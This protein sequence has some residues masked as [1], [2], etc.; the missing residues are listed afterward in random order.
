[1]FYLFKS[2]F[3]YAGRDRWKIILF[4]FLHSLSFCGLLAKPFAF[5]KAINE[6]QIHGIENLNPAISWLGLY[7][8][9]FFVF[10]VFHR[11][12]QIFVVTTALNTQRRF[13]STMYAEL[14]RLPL[15]WHVGHHSG[16]VVNRINTAG[17]ALR[18]FTY[19]M[20]PYLE[21]LF[22]SVGPIVLLTTISWQAAVISFV[23][24]A[25]N[26]V[27]V[28]ILNRKIQ[29]VMHRQNESNH[30]FTA[31]LIDFVSNIRTIITFRIGRETGRELNSKFDEFYRE[32]MKEF[33]LNQPRC[34][35]I[36]FGIIVTEITV[37]SYYL[38]SLRVEMLPLLVGDL[39]I[40]VSY[41]R[42]IS[43]TFFRMTSS[44]YETMGWK[45]AVKSVEPILDGGADISSWEGNAEQWRE[46]K[47][48]GLCFQY[49]RDRETLA[50]ID[51]NLRKGNKIALVGASGSGKSTLLQ[52][53]AG[54]YTPGAVKVEVD[55]RRL[56]NLRGL[57]ESALLIPQDSEI[58]QG[59]ILYNITFGLE[60]GSDELEQVVRAAQFQEVVHRLPRG[61]NTDIREKGVNLSGGERQRLALARGL[62]FARSKALLLLDEVT[63]NVDARNEHHIFRQV[64]ARFSDRCIIAAVHRLHLLENFDYVYMM[65]A[66]RVVQRGTFESLHSS[67]GPFR[68]LWNTYNQSKNSEDTAV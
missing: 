11:L 14:Y 30:A 51:L 42:E 26:L 28:E 61:I 40:I 1:M 9:G 58:F 20:Y 57:T 52:M 27:V 38:W 13:I 48:E 35:L 21:C 54:L 67:P 18:S 36:G 31:R 62:F 15:Q 3:K 5:G 23:F 50:N 12:G 46:A 53:L 45:Q 49:N 10:E 25:F 66:G 59:T 39:V 47:I 63:S 65:A 34:F 16:D 8:A 29:V 32:N 33:R 55:G 6:L 44:F 41:F 24:S 64:F 68:N 7:V 43:D 56:D 4:V 22:M 37:I 60:C 19:S 17:Q 2:I